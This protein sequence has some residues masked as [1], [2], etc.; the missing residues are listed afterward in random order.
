MLMPSTAPA[1]VLPARSAQLAA[2]AWSAPSVPTV[3]LTVGAAG[4][5]PASAHDQL[6]TTSVLFQPAPLAAGVRDAKVVI[7]LVV[8][9]L[10]WA[11][12]A[13]AVLPA[14]SVQVPLSAWSAP[15]VAAV[16]VTVPDTTPD[17]ASVH[18]HTTVTSPRFQPFGLA[19]VRDC[20]VIE[21]GVR[22]TAM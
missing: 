2:A 16:A 12:V 1:V 21:G 22:S 6:T 5:E 15:S 11:S 9:M 7:G 4:P 8:S 14:A 13:E 18:A 3:V 10:M 20:N 17:F 19:A